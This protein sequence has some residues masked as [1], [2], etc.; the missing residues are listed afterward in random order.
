MVR[1]EDCYLGFAQ[2]QP[3]E[4]HGQWETDGDGCVREI[5]NLLHP[6]SRSIADS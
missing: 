1:L 4:S 3:G 6:P 5:D 2:I